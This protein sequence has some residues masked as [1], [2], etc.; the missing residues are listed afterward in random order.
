MGGRSVMRLVLGLAAVTLCLLGAVGLF[1][2][3][4]EGQEDGQAS[5]AG[6]AQGAETPA[7][8]SPA[9]ES[10]AAVPPAAVPPAA[11]PL[12][13]VPPSGMPT[14]QVP[15]EQVA[16]PALEAQDKVSPEAE[17]QARLDGMAGNAVL[18]E[19]VT[20]QLAREL[21]LPGLAGHL[22]E[23]LVEGEGAP[24]IMEAV[25]WMPE[26]VEALVASG[27]WRP[28]DLKEW[29]WLAVMAL[30]HELHE[31][32]PKSLE[33]SMALENSPARYIAAGLSFTPDDQ[34]YGI[35]SEGFRHDDPNNR[36]YSALAVSS[37]GHEDYMAALR[38][39]FDDPHHWTRANALAS[40]IRLDDVQ[41]IQEALNLFDY[42]DRRR[43][44]Q[45]ISSLFEALERAAPH[46]NVLKFVAEIAPKLVGVERAAADAILVLHGELRDTV[47]IREPLLAMSIEAYELP[48]GV[49]A[50]SDHPTAEGLAVLVELFHR[51]QYLQTTVELTVSLAK[52]G[53]PEVESLLRTAALTLPWNQA[54][55]AAGGARA[56]YGEETVVRWIEELPEGTAPERARLLGWALGEFGGETAVNRLRKLP[57]QGMA[58]LGARLGA[59][60]ASAPR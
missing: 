26:T 27:E 40:L 4:S 53:S 54:L 59:L 20:L 50:I 37:N 25:Q 22:R 51:P 56:A 44:V 46:P 28:Q 6:S 2:C 19:A 45:V 38:T 11:V 55:L 49:R 43:P 13:A 36:A 18:L 9:T 42:P 39:A 10:T 17:H 57:A 23:V 5:G 12:A 31:S 1:A 47:T 7:A 58:L 32:M 48:R 35:L 30:W 16:E 3:S 41:G 21:R 15:T 33:L 14:E 24:R 8:E 34:L 52:A 60:A 29:K